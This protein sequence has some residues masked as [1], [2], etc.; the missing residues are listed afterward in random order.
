MTKDDDPIGKVIIIIIVV[1]FLLNTL[2]AYNF[3]Y[4]NGS[5][6]PGLLTRNKVVLYC[7]EKL[8]LCK[9]EYNNIKTQNK[10]NEYQPPEIK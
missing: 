6:N 9:E 4:T 3:G 1:M 5:K 2:V 7:I 10:L 8:D